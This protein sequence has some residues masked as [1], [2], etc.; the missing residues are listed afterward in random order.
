MGVTAEGAAFTEQTA[1]WRL[2]ASYGRELLFDAG[3]MKA[4]FRASDL[5]GSFDRTV[6]WDSKN[7][8]RAGLKLG[9]E[10][11]EGLSFNARVDGQWE[12]SDTHAVAGGVEATWRF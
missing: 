5:K 10:N 11:R 3:D 2:H 1:Y 6:Q 9:I 12:S 7:R 4:A 8:F